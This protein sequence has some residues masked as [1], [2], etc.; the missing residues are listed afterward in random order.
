MEIVIIATSSM[1]LNISHRATLLHF[2]IFSNT[3]FLSA[4]CYTPEQVASHTKNSRQSQLYLFSIVDKSS[5]YYGYLCHHATP[6]TSC[7]M[8]VW[9]LMLKGFLAVKP[10]PMVLWST[11]LRHAVMALTVFHTRRDMS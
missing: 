8:S 4:V 2:G 9:M 5:S 1:E 10:I 6:T 3:M 7:I 11:S